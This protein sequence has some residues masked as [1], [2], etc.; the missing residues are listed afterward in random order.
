MIDSIFKENPDKLFILI[1]GYNDAVIGFEIDDE[2]HLIY[3]QDKMYEIMLENGFED[4]D[5]CIEWFYFNIQCLSGLTNGPI[6]V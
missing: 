5:E 2:S 3:N 6:F 1:D 4:I